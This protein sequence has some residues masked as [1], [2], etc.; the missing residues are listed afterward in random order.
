MLVSNNPKDLPILIWKLFFAGERIIYKG[1]ELKFH[2][3]LNG[4]IKK[5]QVGDY[6][7]LEQNPKK[8]SRFGQMARQGAK[9]LWIIHAP[10]N[11]WVKRVIDQKVKELER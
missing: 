9:I 7:Y 11:Q 3:V 1:Q 8:G 10:T 4:E 5:I 2:R 6:I